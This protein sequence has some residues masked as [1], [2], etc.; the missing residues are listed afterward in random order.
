MV[1]WKANG[2]PRSEC[3]FGTTYMW[4][5]YTFVIASTMLPR[6]T[7]KNSTMASLIWR[8][9]RHVLRSPC[10]VSRTQHFRRTIA[11]T[12]ATGDASNLPLAGIKV[13]D[14]TRVL[15]GVSGNIHIESNE[16]DSHRAIL[17]SNIGRSRVREGQ[18]C[19]DQLPRLAVRQPRLTIRQSRCDQD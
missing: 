18:S 11:S 7:T 13:L 6:A 2:E 4:S 5:T 8:G 19:M 17:Y 14:M 9:S 3:E 15:A 12:A 10:F 1:G 16:T